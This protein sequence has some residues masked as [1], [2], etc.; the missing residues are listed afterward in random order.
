MYGGWWR[1]EIIMPRH[2]N[3][4]RTRTYKRNFFSCFP[5]SSPR[6]PPYRWANLPIL[7]LI[8]HLAD[9]LI[10]I[11]SLDC[12]YFHDT[13]VLGGAQINA[14]LPLLTKTEVRYSILLAVRSVPCLFWIGGELKGERHIFLTFSNVPFVMH[15]YLL[16][17]MNRSVAFNERSI[18]VIIIIP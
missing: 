10:T 8:V 1:L 7:I 5:F 16:C 13:Q 15:V 6:T 17:I 4:C 12:H 3:C 9:Y 11:E 2:E 14:S 18:V